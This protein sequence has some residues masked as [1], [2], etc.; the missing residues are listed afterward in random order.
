MSAEDEKSKNEKPKKDP[1]VENEKPKKMK[2][3]KA[4]CKTKCQHNGVIVDK[5]DVVEFVGSIPAAKKHL[6]E[7]AE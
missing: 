2:L 3:I 6:F 5:G 1:E 7:E 4:V